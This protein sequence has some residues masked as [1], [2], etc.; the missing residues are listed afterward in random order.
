MPKSAKSTLGTSGL[1]VVICMTAGCGSST[2]NTQSG[3][4]GH[5]TVEAQPPVAFEITSRPH[6]TAIRRNRVVLRGTAALGATLEI[7]DEPVN[8][9]ES[10]KWRKT[11]KLALGDNSI[12]FHAS[13]WLGRRPLTRW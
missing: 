7:D 11:V 4:S 9:N 8:V 2:S 6:E 5:S 3:S 13:T 12:G 10:G 1:L